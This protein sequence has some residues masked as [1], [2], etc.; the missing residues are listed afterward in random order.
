ML[1]DKIF[2]G[3]KPVQVRYIVCDIAEITQIK[4]YFHKQICN[5][6]QGLPV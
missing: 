1:L 2:H 5:R 6:R 3:L 4:H